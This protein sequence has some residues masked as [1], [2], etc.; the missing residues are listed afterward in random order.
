MKRPSRL[1]VLVFCAALLMV[2]SVGVAVWWRA[3]ANPPPTAADAPRR[4]PGDRA[5]CLGFVDAEGGVVSLSPVQAGRVA[6]VLVQENETV[7][8]GAELLRL[9]DAVL[10]LRADEAQAALRGAEAV[11]AE[12]REQAG[13][14]SVRVA[15]QRGAVEAARRRLAAARAQQRRQENLRE[16]NQIAQEDVTVAAEQVK[17]LEA[18]AGAEESKLQ[19]MSNTDTQL[20]VQRAE[21]D[22]AQAQARLKQAQDGVNE[23]V[24]KAPAAGQV[25]R[26]LAAPGEL[27]GPGTRP[28]AVQFAAAGPRVVRAEVLQEFADRVA[29]G[30]AAAVSDDNNPQLTW[31][32]EVVRIADWYTPRRVVSLDTAPGAELYVLECVIRLKPGGTPPRINQRVRV[33]LGGPAR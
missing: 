13:Q 10:R 2:A 20:P 30:Q 8:Q 15:A 25:L 24:L 16:K 1:A 11:L 23:C 26:L 3:P 22:V 33:L 7:A 12:A 14:Q 31:E 5:A 27:A 6:R 21:A 4:P 19:A 29:V 28:A 9:D 32:G 18:L 17:E